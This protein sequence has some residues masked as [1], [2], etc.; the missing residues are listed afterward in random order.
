VQLLVPDRRSRSPNPGGE[1]LEEA[2]QTFVVEQRR[3]LDH[4]CRRLAVTGL[5]NPSEYVGEVG[6]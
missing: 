1:E 2:A 3:S 5:Q 6:R 4:A